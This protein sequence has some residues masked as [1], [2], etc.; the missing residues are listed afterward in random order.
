MGEV[1]GKEKSIITSRVVVGSIGISNPVGEGRRV[2]VIVLKEL[3]RDYRSH[4][5]SHRF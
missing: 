3:A 2:R 1:G 5:P 4:Y